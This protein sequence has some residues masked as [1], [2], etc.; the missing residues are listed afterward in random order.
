M[1]RESKAV[2]LGLFPL[3]AFLGEEWALYSP[4][5]PIILPAFLLSFLFLHI[6]S[7]PQPTNIL[8]RTNEQK[9]TKTYGLE[10]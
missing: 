10:R 8:K 9:K 1:Q 2:G 4:R 5:R 6:K 3:S 7:H